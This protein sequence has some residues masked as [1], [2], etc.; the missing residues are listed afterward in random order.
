LAAAVV[1]VSMSAC[2]NRAAPM[3]VITND[4]GDPAAEV[5]PATPLAHTLDVPAADATAPAPGPGPR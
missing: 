1:A 3:P 5:A 2:G 4:P